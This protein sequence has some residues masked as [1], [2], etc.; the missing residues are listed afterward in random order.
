[1][2]A[3]HR[4]HTRALTEQTFFQGSK[5]RNSLPCPLV[6]VADVPWRLYQLHDDAAGGMMREVHWLMNPP[7]PVVDVRVV[8]R[9]GIAYR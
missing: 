4:P 5:A 8:E 1:M 3:Q 2:G 7:L 6:V 9:G